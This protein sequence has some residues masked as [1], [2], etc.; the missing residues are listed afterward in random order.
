MEKLISLPNYIISS[1]SVSKDSADQC[2]IGTIFFNDDSYTVSMSRQQE[3]KFKAAVKVTFKGNSSIINDTFRTDPC[4][5]YLR[6]INSLYKQKFK[7]LEDCIESAFGSIENY[8]KREGLLTERSLNDAAACEMDLKTEREDKE[9]ESA[10]DSVQLMSLLGVPPKEITPELEP[11]L[12]LNSVS[13]KPMQVAAVQ[14]MVVE[15]VPKPSKQIN[16]TQNSPSQKV[17]KSSKFEEL[18]MVAAQEAAG[19]SPNKTIEKQ[20]PELNSEKVTTAA[21]FFKN[22]NITNVPQITKEASVKNLEQMVSQGYN[23]LVEKINKN[24]SANFETTPIK[25]ATEDNLNTQVSYMRELIGSINNLADSG[26]NI[27]KIFMS[28]ATPEQIS[29]YKADWF[30][31]EQSDLEK[32]IDVI[33]KAD[34]NKIMYLFRKALIRRW[35]D[36]DQEGV[37]K[38]L[39][40]FLDYA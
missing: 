14:D 19:Q 18:R 34:K 7:K 6:Y 12:P 22:N 1:I 15:R 23:D 26:K 37:S 17:P 28:T 4:Q 8:L 33:A 3:D 36:G 38:F 35:R 40:V 16:P 29:R 25:G 32:C 31:K 21:D 24:P 39:E 11:D 9:M 2:Y 27:E 13:H 5:M 20:K 10:T 30:I